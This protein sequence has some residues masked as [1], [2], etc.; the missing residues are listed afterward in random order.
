[1]IGKS[2]YWIIVALFLITLIQY[3]FTPM[4]RMHGLIIDFS[5]QTSKIEPSWLKD[6]PT[7]PTLSTDGNLIIL[8]ANAA[9]IRYG[10]CITFVTVFPQDMPRVMKTGLAKNPTSS[11]HLNLWCLFDDGSRSPAYSADVPIP[12]ER[13][14]TIDCPLNE[15]ARHELWT[16]RRPLHVFLVTYKHQSDQPIPLAQTSITPSRPSSSS[17]EILTLCTSPLRNTYKFLPQWIEFHRQVGFRKFVIYN[18][19]DR[20]AELPSIIDVYSKESPELIDV[21]QW[22]FDHLRVKDWHGQRYFQVEAVHD[23]LFRYGDRSEWL[24]IIDLDEYVVPLP[25]YKRVDEYLRMKFKR[26][27]IGSVVLRSLFFCDVGSKPPKTTNPLVIEQFTQRAKEVM[28]RGRA[29]YLCRPR[30]VQNLGIHYQKY[31]LPSAI[32]VETDLIFAHYVSMSQQRS[33][34]E[35]GA[36]RT[37]DDTRVRELFSENV[38][39]GLEQL[40]LLPVRR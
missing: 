40:G 34:P 5:S 10:G 13:V 20:G 12:Y 18:T 24:G 4:K 38:R 8:S 1:M 32:P 25:P 6:V 15:F 26:E 7:V 37:M 14:S 23:C 11:I 19:T 3:F 35:C 2:L 27:E 17:D 28:K 9:R 39:T 16:E 22:N 29:K 33:F 36:N 21:V 31:G 30:F